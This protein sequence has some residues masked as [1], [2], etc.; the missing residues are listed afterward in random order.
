MIGFYAHHHGS[1]HIQRCRTIMAHLDGDAQLL[2]TAPAADV[3]LPEDAS[4]F[5]VTD[6]TAN[7]TLHYA[8]HHHAGLTQRM[9]MIAAWI[10]EHRP[11]AFYVDVSVEVALLARLMGVPVVTLAMPGERFDGPHQ[12]GYRQASAIIAPWPDWVPVP[13]HLREHRRILHQVGGISRFS[14][15]ADP[16]PDCDVVVLSGRGGTG[17]TEAQWDQ[18]RSACPDRDFLFLGA[19][20]FVDDPMPYLSSA[21][22]VVTAAG[23][24]S[25]A[26]IAVAGAKSI[27]LPQA[28]P[29][30]EQHATAAL[31]A[32]AELALVAETFP[33]AGEWP[34]LLERAEALDSTWLRWQ[35]AGAAVRAAHVIR[36]VAGL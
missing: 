11:D 4:D 26:D 20:T 32:A 33:E 7:G 23:Q 30:A 15:P 6:P 36:K 29:F 25:V 22:V 19:D 2:S 14:R 8:P 17:W 18:V 5:P 34:A 28:R 1:G 24:N 13:P 10:D 31:L 9:A 16:G 27:V 21:N 3:V 35:T 12:L